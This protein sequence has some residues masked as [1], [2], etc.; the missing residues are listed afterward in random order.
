[1]SSVM[2]SLHISYMSEQAFQNS[3]D[4]G[5]VPWFR[6]LLENVPLINLQEEKEPRTFL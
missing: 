6:L 4:L 5:Y 2:C 1:M 3:Y